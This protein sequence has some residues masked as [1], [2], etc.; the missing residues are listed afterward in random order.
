MTCIKSGVI[1]RRGAEGA[2]KEKVESY[3]WVSE[4]LCEPLR[5]LRLCGEAFEVN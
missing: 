5:T 1:H 3:Q 2:E 4:F